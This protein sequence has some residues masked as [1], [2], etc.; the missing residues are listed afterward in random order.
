MN[1]AVKLIPSMNIMGIFCAGNP[2]RFSP[3]DIN[4]VSGK[5]YGELY[6]RTIKR[7]QRI[8]DLGYNLIIKWETDII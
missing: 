6:Q 7:D 8:R 1:F 2:K 5:I 4:T 3:N